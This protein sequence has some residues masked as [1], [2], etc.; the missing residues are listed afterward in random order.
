[1]KYS[2]SLRFL[3]MYE[4]EVDSD[5]NY[6]GKYLAWCRSRNYSDERIAQEQAA[7]QA[8]YYRLRKLD[9]ESPEEWYDLSAYEVIFSDKER[10]MLNPDGTPR[11]D[12]LEKIAGN[13]RAISEVMVLS[14]EKINEIEEFNRLVKYWAARG[15][16]FAKDELDRRADQNRNAS[17]PLNERELADLR[18][19]EE[20]SSLTVDVDP[21]EYYPL[22]QQ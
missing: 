4:S 7:M 6:H 3:N 10:E 1:M 5:C 16:N 21:S 9:E 17:R 15:V 19:F 18:N 14:E 12:Y 11:E 2:R 8:E 20:I 22:T 13:E